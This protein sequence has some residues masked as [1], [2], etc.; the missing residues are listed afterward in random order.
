M[1]VFYEKLQAAAL[2]ALT[3]FFSWFLVFQEEKEEEEGST[4]LLMLLLHIYL[5][6]TAAHDFKG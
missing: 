3:L 6:V 2:S 5:Y 4:L 1:C